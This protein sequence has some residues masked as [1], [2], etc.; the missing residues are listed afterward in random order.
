MNFVQ[1]DKYL[2][3]HLFFLQFAMLLRE[4][5]KFYSQDIKHFKDYPSEADCCECESPFGK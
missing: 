2:P 1:I 3:I 5:V 4:N